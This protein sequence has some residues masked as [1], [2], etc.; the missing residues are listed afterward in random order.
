MT[1]PNVVQ[2]Y[3]PGSPYFEQEAQAFN[4]IRDSF[5][6]QM[7]GM[8]RPPSPVAQQAAPG[9]P[10]Q[11][12]QAPPSTAPSVPPPMTPDAPDDALMGAAQFWG[13]QGAEA[14]P[15]AQVAALVNQYRG[16]ARPSEQGFATMLGASGV[17]TLQLSAFTG[18]G[19]SL[20]EGAQHLPIVGEALGRIH[21]LHQADQWLHSMDEAVRSA[22][23][24]SLQWTNTVAQTTGAIGAMWYPAAG[25]WALAGKIG[26]G[27]A[28]F[29]EA[30]GPTWGPIVRAA[31][32]GS[33]TALALSGRWLTQPFQDAMGQDNGQ[34]YLG[35]VAQGFQ[36]EYGAVSSGLRDA[37]LGEAAAA[38]LPQVMPAAQKLGNAIAKRFV[39]PEM[40]QPTDLMDM[41][42]EIPGGL[43]QYAQ[44]QSNAEVLSNLADMGNPQ[45]QA[46]QDYRIQQ[47]GVQA[48]GTAQAEAVATQMNKAAGIINSPSVAGIAQSAA[49]NDVVAAAGAMSANPGGT[50][51]I[52][53]VIDPPT[54][55]EQLGGAYVKFAPHGT[56]L[57][58]LVSDEPITDQMVNEYIQH[59][60]FTGQGALLPNGVE[61][62]I[63]Q[64]NAGIV[65]VRPAL[66]G[67]E[68][69]VL[70]EDIM[71]T[72]N[73]AQAKD[74]SGMWDRYRAY[75]DQRVGAT[76]AA[77][78]GGAINPAR[79]ETLRLQNRPGYM[80]DFFQAQG[81]DQSQAARARSYFN[82]RFI[83]DLKSQAP[84]EFIAA[85]VAQGQAT[86]AP[87]PFQ[88]PT[89]R[90]DQAAASKG[91]VAIPGGADG[92]MHVVDA[93][94]TAAEPMS[95]S[96][97]SRQAAEAWVRNVQRDLP[98]I[99]PPG[100]VPM[101]IIGQLPTE[102]TQLPNINHLEAQASAD[103]MADTEPLNPA[104]RQQ[105]QMLAS[106]G[107]LGQMQ[108]EYT[109]GMSRFRWMTNMI[110]RMDQGLKGAGIDLGFSEDHAELLQRHDQMHNYLAPWVMRSGEIN[111]QVRPTLAAS[112]D[113]ELTR[114]IADPAQRF[115]QAQELGFRPAEVQAMIDRT[116][117]YRDVFPETELDPLRQL[118]N[119]VSHVQKRQSIPGFTGNAWDEYDGLTEV[120]RPFWQYMRTGNVNTRE[121]DPRVLDKM[122][123]YSLAWDKYMA[124][125]YP[126]VAA[127]YQGI[128]QNVPE[129]APF[130]DLFGNW[131]RILKYGPDAANDAG[132]QA[133]QGI[134]SK[135]MGSPVT[136]QQTRQLFNLTMNSTYDALLGFQP[137]ILARDGLRLMFAAPKVGAGEL[138]GVLSDYLF[139]GSAARQQMWDFATQAG[140]SRTLSPFLHNPLSFEQADLPTFE[141]EALNADPQSWRMQA[142]SWLGKQIGDL[143]PAWFRDPTPS[144]LSPMYWISKQSE[145]MRMFVGNAAYRKADAAI[146]AFRQG[147]SQDLD[148]LLGDSGVRTM[149][150]ASIDIFTK[151][152]AGGDDEAAKIYAARQMTDNTMF[153]YG[154]LET[155]VAMQS[156]FGRIGM[157]M[158]NFAGHVYSYAKAG[159]TQGNLTDKL[160]F[161]ASFLA[162]TAG[163][164]ELSKQTGWD[165]RRMNP[166]AGLGFSGGPWLEPAF[167]VAKGVGA[168]VH[169]L[170]GDGTQ[171]DQAA[172][173]TAGG[174]L[175]NAAQMFN[176]LRGAMRTAEG[177]GASLQ[178]PLPGHA[179]TRLMVTG[180]S[181]PGPDFNTV[182]L[183]Q[184]E[185]AFQ[186]SLQ[187]I[188]NP[189]RAT[190]FGTTQIPPQMPV[191]PAGMP[192][193][194]SPSAGFQQPPNQV[195]LPGGQ[196][197][198]YRPNPASQN[199]NIPT[200]QQPNGQPQF[201]QRNNNPGNLQYAGQPGATLGDG[202]F[203][204]FQ[205][206]VD[207]YNALVTQ[208][209]LDASRGHTIS[210]FVAKYAPAPQNDT[211][212]YINF[213]SHALGAHPDTPLSQ[214]PP[215]S[216]ARAVAQHESQ[217]AV[218]QGGGPNGSGY[219]NSQPNG[220]RF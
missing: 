65:G 127:K 124:D 128:A 148:Q 45:A 171:N 121:L 55:A 38:I 92:T 219:P 25:A 9:A 120:T 60:M 43:P 105:A 139:G 39:P 187:P 192:Q 125:F 184:S 5:F 143:T 16:Q 145:M 177:I 46:L 13:I 136:T 29:T 123:F 96:F 170:A 216:I 7:T 200:L 57:D 157:Q 90:L 179:L 23:P 186:A 166:Y 48:L 20:L 103:A 79:L 202:G 93:T 112:G 172:L 106:S 183:P 141:D 208:V 47:R 74:V 71:P 95:I 70:P 150:P 182:M 28:A 167:D 190:A 32:Q 155:P 189:S 173:T 49:P 122:Y 4:A 54:L 201:A 1:A 199:V 88:T 185:A 18:A 42:I 99:T 84:A 111:A 130:T 158:G 41:A 176:P 19:E 100:E 15:K 73:T 62:R 129:L 132:I 165:F 89:Q 126:A 53:G 56:R 181:G 109:Q 36:H 2:M 12:P 207:G 151:H 27:A 101:D 97:T 191:F 21:A 6:Q 58:A 193:A 72:L 188:P 44:P 94:G 52:Q 115:A 66:G 83:D 91:F 113:F 117:M 17:N 63:T 194:F 86:S 153:R 51:I 154:Q 22:T 81:L 162:V 118:D 146:E 80:Q 140:I 11:P 78:G 211:T 10:G 142:A 68:F 161:G 69:F 85:E 59:G 214:F 168:A 87:A 215:D 35:N 110:H 108:L 3:G 196:P 24:E 204:R 137:H 34:G 26:G 104:L 30:F 75:E 175:S 213:L 61:G 160:K 206:P 133:M 149:D 119:Y 147:G 138:G 37:A 220:A 180:E 169:T 50:N 156:T 102:P 82:L 203:A 8:Q 134:A 212:A 131:L 164:E 174:A 135:L 210:S 144:R 198:G 107:K 205:S 178:S 31:G 217:T 163:L 209:G 67:A 98:D 76:D 159:L 14:M 114:E 77:M 218:Q 152:V 40:L 195:P 33:A 197:Y 64:I 116:Q